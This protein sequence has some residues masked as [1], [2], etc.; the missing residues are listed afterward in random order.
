MQKYTIPTP[1]RFL[2]KILFSA[3]RD[4]V[5]TILQGV[6]FRFKPSGEVKIASTDGHRLSWVLKEYNSETPNYEDITVPYQQLKQIITDEE[7]NFFVDEE[8][9]SI[10]GK[11]GGLKVDGFPHYEML[12]PTE[13]SKH[14]T[15]RRA[16]VLL[17][18]KKV[19]TLESVITL[20][21]KESEDL[22]IKTLDYGYEE[23]FPCS[24]TGEPLTIR[25]N[26]KYFIQ[27][28]SNFSG[29]INFNGKLHPAVFP[30]GHLIMPIQS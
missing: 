30:T 23:S 20:S 8:Y 18:L 28:L 14:L 6:N 29:E 13:F 24:Y 10:N 11:I 16:Q 15:I 4:P 12:I 3:S 19:K 5:K 25:F 1:P 21:M 7:I 22:I 2:S 9:F 26:L 17:F 27:A